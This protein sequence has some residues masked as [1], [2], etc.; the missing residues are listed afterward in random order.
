MLKLIVALALSV[1]FQFS[2]WPKQSLFIVYLNNCKKIFLTLRYYKQ[3]PAK[4]LLNNSNDL[5][6][7]AYVNTSMLNCYS[8]CSETCK[9]KCVSIRQ[10]FKTNYDK[11]FQEYFITL[12]YNNFL[13]RNRNP[14]QNIFFFFFVKNQNLN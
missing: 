2:H 4:Y 8:N 1:H 14:N 6:Q 5:N 9:N 3:V 12:K 10:E 13:N 7:K 11:L